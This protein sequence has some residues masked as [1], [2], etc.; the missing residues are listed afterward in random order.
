VLRLRSVML[1]LDFMVGGW[2]TNAAPGIML[3][4]VVVGETDRRKIRFCPKD[5]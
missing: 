5:T 1:M 3:C 2:T 4:V